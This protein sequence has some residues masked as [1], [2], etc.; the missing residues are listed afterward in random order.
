M[1]MSYSSNV[2]SE[3]LSE[4]DTASATDQ[5]SEF[6]EEQFNHKLRYSHRTIL[7]LLSNGETEDASPQQEIV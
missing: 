3:A 7:S 2:F 1:H 5:L 4:N 6:S